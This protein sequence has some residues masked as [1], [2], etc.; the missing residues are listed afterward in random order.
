MD[1]IYDL[2]QAEYQNE[3]IEQDDYKHYEC[4]YV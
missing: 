1:E 3:Q 4:D 2:Y